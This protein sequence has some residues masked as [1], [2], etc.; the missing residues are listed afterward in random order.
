[1]SVSQNDLAL[2]V[3]RAQAGDRS[4]FD[5]IYDRFTDALYRFLYSR[6]GDAALAEELLGDLWVRVVEHLPQL[7]L[8]EGNAEA[9][10]A[11]WL[12]RIARNLTVDAFRR[13]RGDVPLLETISS[14]ERAPDDIVI[15]DDEQRELRAAFAQLTSEQREVLL[16]RFFEDRSNAEVAA[17]TGRSEG[18]VKVMQHRALGSLAR[19]LGI[20]RKRGVSG[21]NSNAATCWTPACDDC[22]RAKS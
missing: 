22:E 11:A 1:M 10:F 18:A 5:A 4:A 21:T 17:L 14:R 9:A 7:R 2:L 16:L 6:C 15:A 13:R 12:Y 20:E 8:P 3:K 19:L